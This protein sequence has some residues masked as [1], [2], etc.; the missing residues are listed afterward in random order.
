MV[1]GP[2]LTRTFWCSLQGESSPAFRLH[3]KTPY[4]RK[5]RADALSQIDNVRVAR[6]RI[7]SE[8]S[9]VRLKKRDICLLIVPVFDPIVTVVVAPIRYG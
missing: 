1:R 3:L 5:P 6:H 4:E 7:S 2:S 8:F 9:A